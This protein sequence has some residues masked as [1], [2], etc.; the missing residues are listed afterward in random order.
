MS[1]P[2]PTR[3]FSGRVADYE[4]GRP[5]YPAAL[6]DRLLELAGL[7]EGAVAADLG[8]GTG[9]SSAPLL[10]RGL[11]V[12]A[13]EPNA[14]M[15]EAAERRLAGRPGFRAVDGA[16]EATGLDD[17]SVDLVF[18]AQAF[19]WFDLDR[20]RAEASR[21]LRPDGWAALAWNA[22]RAAGRPFLES[23]ERL[24][25][26]FG[27]DYG[28]VG[29]RGVAAGK[30]ARFFG[31]EPLHERFENAQT[32]DLDGIRAR[33]L[34][35]SYVPAA[36]QPGHDEML[37]ELQRIFARHERGGAVEILYDVDLFAGPLR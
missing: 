25:L 23:Y 20:T 4:R 3:R 32:L 34:S 16:A 19:H 17:A 37:E 7:G 30:L 27:T 29:H 31:A 13:V 12:F 22:R 18:A 11:E 14:A 15:R 2:D 26:D 10:E 21:I 9:L 5:G 28:D 36:G 24:L 1:R 35:S 6:F 8:A 33:L